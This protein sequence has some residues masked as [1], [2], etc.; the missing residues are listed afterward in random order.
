MNVRLPLKTTLLA[1]SQSLIWLAEVLLR[2][3]NPSCAEDIK[4]TL[5]SM[6]FWQ[7]EEVWGGLSGPPLK[8][9]SQDDF[10]KDKKLI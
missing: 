8:N 1:N 3:Q 9:M 4:L 2:S 7:N 5:F 10:W 6:G